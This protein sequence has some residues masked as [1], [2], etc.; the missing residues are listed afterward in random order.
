MKTKTFSL[1]VNDLFDELKD[2]NKRLLKE[3]L[4]AE[5]KIKVLEK[6]RN[7]LNNFRI[8]CCNEKIVNKLNFEDLENEYQ[9]LSNNENESKTEETIVQTNDDIISEEMETNSREISPHKLIDWTSNSSLKRSIKRINDLYENGSKRYLKIN[10]IKNKPIVNNITTDP[11]N[12][13]SVK[14]SVNNYSGR[15]SAREEFLKVQVLKEN[16][17]VLGINH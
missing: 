4:F 17:F 6:F 9:L 2:E 5:R 13:E 16:E 7:H 12:S 15:A 10:V 11:K 3:L 1:R 8:Y 14:K